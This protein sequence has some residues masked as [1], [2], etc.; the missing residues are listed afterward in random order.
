MNPF[1][2]EPRNHFSIILSFTIQ[3]LILAPEEITEQ[4]VQAQP[5]PCAVDFRYLVSP[6]FYSDLPPS[7]PSLLLNYVTKIRISHNLL[8]APVRV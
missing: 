8:L 1:G 4:G 2:L 6:T 5:V 7:K 3:L